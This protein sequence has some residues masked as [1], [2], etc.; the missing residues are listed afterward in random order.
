MKKTTSN[1]VFIWGI[2][3]LAIAGMMSLPIM[4]YAQGKNKPWVVPEK[5]KALKNPVKSDEAS[6]NA[7]KALFNKNCKSCHGAKGQGD[8]PKSKELETP[9][10]DFSTDLKA[11]TDGELF[12]KIKEGREDMPGYGKK[13]PD[14]NDIWTL[15]NYIRSFGGTDVKKQEQT[16][17][18]Q[19]TGTQQPKKNTGTDTTKTGA[20][21]T[22]TGKAVITKPDTSKT[23]PVKTGQQDQTEKI[24]TTYQVG[25]AKITVREK[26]KQGENGEIKIKSF[27]IGKASA[28]NEQGDI[29]YQFD[30]IELLQLKSAIDKAIIGEIGVKKE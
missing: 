18:G 22:E 20:I 1:K 27:E 9:T 13:I 16:S 2:I 3:I 28:K 23:N 7:G 19:V 15:V 4:S 14:D 25:D 12:F 6:L 5:S 21:K 10:G 24:M 11:Q 17:S 26:I 30:E 8:G 29:K